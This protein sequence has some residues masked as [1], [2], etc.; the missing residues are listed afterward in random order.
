MVSIKIDES[1]MVNINIKLDIG[2]ARKDIDILPGEEIVYLRGVPEVFPVLIEKV[3]RVFGE[4]DPKDKKGFVP[5]STE[6]GGY[7]IILK[8][9]HGP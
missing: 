4:Y 2:D 7:E 5:G 1:G 6:H 8:E 3:M 9:L